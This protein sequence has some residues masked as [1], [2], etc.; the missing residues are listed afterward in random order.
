MGSLDRKLAGTSG[1]G[2]NKRPHVTLPASLQGG[3]FSGNE[4]KKGPGTGDGE[5]DGEHN[6]RV[7]LPAV[8]QALHSAHVL[9]G[10][11]TW[12]GEDGRV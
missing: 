10:I 12:S 4:D 6:E 3:R 9:L 5:G 8:L 7:R 11:G 1:G 2:D